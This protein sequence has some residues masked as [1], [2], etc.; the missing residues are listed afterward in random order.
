MPRRKRLTK[1]QKRLADVR[2]ER[3]VAT[4]VIL[5]VID[6]AT[7]ECTNRMSIPDAER[8]I[9]L[10]GKSWDEFWLAN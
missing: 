8:T 1:D 4:G 3:A 9:T 7:L 10:R 2:R 6:S 5:A